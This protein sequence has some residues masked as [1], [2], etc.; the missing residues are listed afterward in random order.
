M[1]ESG[2]TSADIAQV[3]FI[4]LVVGSGVGG[5]IYAALKNDK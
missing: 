2:L 1:Q 3:I 4:I 5:F